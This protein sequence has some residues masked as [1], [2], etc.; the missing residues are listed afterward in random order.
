MKMWPEGL[1][2]RYAY[3]LLVLKLYR[4]D[5]QVGRLRITKPDDHVPS[6]NARIWSG[7]RCHSR[8]GLGRFFVNEVLK[9]AKGEPGGLAD[10][11]RHAACPH[12]DPLT[13]V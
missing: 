9:I 2:C 12:V 5:N 13:G 7:R 1:D 11:L 4:R 8:P 10:S 6:F 3:P